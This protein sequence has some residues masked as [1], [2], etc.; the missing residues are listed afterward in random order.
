MH[1][2][3]RAC[4]FRVPPPSPFPSK[5]SESSDKEE[6]RKDSRL[7]SRKNFLAIGQ[8]SSLMKGI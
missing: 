8:G 2:S 1:Y 5:S 3:R 4:S 6:Q 7:Y